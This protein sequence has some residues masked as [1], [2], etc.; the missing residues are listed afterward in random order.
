M[1]TLRRHSRVLIVIL[2]I[3]FVVGHVI[4]FHIWRNGSPSR[5]TFSG[6]A[7]ATIIVL[8]VAKHLGLAAALVRSLQ[9]HFR[10]RHN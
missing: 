8:M 6:I 7:V 2:T 10:R 1:N 3:G 5:L 9:S 4:L